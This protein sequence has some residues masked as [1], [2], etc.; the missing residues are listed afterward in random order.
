MLLLKSLYFILFFSLSS[1]P[2]YFAVYISQ[3]LGI[4][5]DIVGIIQA[6]SPLVSFVMSP[7]WAAIVDRT[8]L[9][10]VVLVVMPV[11]SVCLL[12]LLPFLSGAP[13]GYLFAVAI[14]NSIAMSPV[15]SLL[16]TMVLS[17]LPDPE[18]YGQQRLFGGLACGVGSFVTGFATDKLGNAA[19]FYI[20]S[21]GV[22]LFCAIVI[23]SPIPWRFAVHRP[24][25]SPAAAA[26]ETQPCLPT[27]DHQH[28]REKSDNALSDSETERDHRSQTKKSAARSL[29]NKHEEGTTAAVDLEAA[30]PNSPHGS[31]TTLAASVR[32][33][34]QTSL[35]SLCTVSVG[36]FLVI[37]LLMGVVFCMVSSFLWLYMSDHLH[38]SKTF[39]GLTSPFQIAMEIPFFFWS[40][41]VIRRMGVNRMILAAHIAMI[42]RVL[43]YTVLPQDQPSYAILGIETLHGLSFAWLFSAAVQ[44]AHDLAPVGADATTQAI[45]ASVYSNLGGFIGNIAGGQ[46]Y[47]RAGPRVMFYA[48]AGIVA[49]SLVVFTLRAVLDSRT[50]PPLDAKPDQTTTAPA[51]A[52]RSRR[53]SV[54]AAHDPRRAS[55]AS[56]SCLGSTHSIDAALA[57]VVVAADTDCTAALE[58]VPVH[59]HTD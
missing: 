53:A 11:L 57:A 35:S 49:L 13:V 58:F 29:A 28:R 51:P 52:V 14:G 45:V 46:L 3:T 44:I 33:N 50:R 27:T 2:A 20:Y 22:A 17:L 18:L 32:H 12:N 10:K 56:M 54:A 42:V 16:D 34:N 21:I 43:L 1:L 6:V 31:D 40:K 8:R 38:A 30:R 26:G 59:P 7:V 39:L 41:T 15:G 25:A 23:T 9:H 55:L 19:M 37:M 48:M 47:T 24:H 36:L 4:A 5:A